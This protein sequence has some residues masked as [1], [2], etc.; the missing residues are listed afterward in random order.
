MLMQSQHRIA[1][2]VMV[3]RFAGSQ[4]L[5]LFNLCTCQILLY[6]LLSL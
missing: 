4:N 1:T 5:V 3:L 2:M 6:N